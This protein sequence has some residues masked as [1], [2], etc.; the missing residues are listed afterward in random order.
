[1]NLE[2]VENQ[3]D[4]A[5][6]DRNEDLMKANKDE[7]LSDG[8][9]LNNYLAVGLAEGFEESEDVSDVIK[10]WAY[11]QR[12]GMTATLQGFFGRTCAS[13]IEKGFFDVNGVIDWDVINE[14]LK[15]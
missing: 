15:D 10:A 7:L 11:V 1:M 6:I 12:H 2:Q 8:I 5:N 4:D 9:K 13:M 14:A 3:M